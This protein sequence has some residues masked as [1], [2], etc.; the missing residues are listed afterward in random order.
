MFLVFGYWFVVW[1]LVYGLSLLHLLFVKN[2]FESLSTKI[3]KNVFGIG[4]GYRELGISKIRFRKNK[5]SK[6]CVLENF[7]VFSKNKF[8]KNKY[9]SKFLIQEIRFHS[10]DYSQFPMNF[11][12]SSDLYP[13]FWPR[14]LRLQYSRAV[15]GTKVIKM[16]SLKNCY[17]P[18]KI[19][20]INSFCKTTNMKLFPQKIRKKNQIRKISVKT[21]SRWQILTRF[22][23]K[24]NKYETLLWC[25]L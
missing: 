22:D 14:D 9:T 15:F 2:V 23:H 25:H 5:F 10:G 13:S 1:Y 24:I 8:S 11:P 7:E 21:V 3:S 16:M 20:T 4:H 6:V 17:V 19:D 18:K 12:M